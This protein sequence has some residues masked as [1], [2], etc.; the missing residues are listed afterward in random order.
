M[1]LSSKIAIHQ[2]NI[3]KT[4]HLVIITQADLPP[5]VQL[6]T[7][8]TLIATLWEIGFKAPQTSKTLIAALTMM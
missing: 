8:I 7:T 5:K 1:Q 3:R 2:L 6:L 4:N